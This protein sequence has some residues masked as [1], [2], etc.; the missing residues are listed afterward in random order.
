MK[1]MALIGACLGLALTTATG[2]VT[3][4]YHED[5]YYDPGPRV[6]HRTVVVDHHNHH[7]HRRHYGHG[8]RRHRPYSP[9]PVV[10]V[11]DRDRH[12]HHHYRGRDRGGVVVT[13]PRPDRPDGTP[14]VT[15]PDRPT[16]PG[17]AM[18]DL[19]REHKEE[20]REQRAE[21]KELARE[22]KAERKENGGRGNAYGHERGRGNPHSSEASAR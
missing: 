16:P 15:R 6:V 8:Y 11:R 12:H 19:K 22:Q 4:V 2:C 20:R 5:G 14:P 3:R 17:H 7:G 18:R 10:V 9:R 21:R 1:R 13:P